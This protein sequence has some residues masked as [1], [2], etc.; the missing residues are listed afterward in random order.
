MET[1]KGGVSFNELGD[2]QEEHARVG[3][4]VKLGRSVLENETFQVWE[5][6]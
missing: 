2:M 3:G 6:T 5:F 1:Q 4:D